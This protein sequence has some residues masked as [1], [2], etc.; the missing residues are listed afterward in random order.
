MTRLRQMGGATKEDRHD[1]DLPGT[2][3]SSRKK[4]LPFAVDGENAAKTGS[5][6]AGGGAIPVSRSWPG[7]RVSGPRRG[8]QS[9]VTGQLPQAACLGDRL[10]GNRQPNP[11]C[12][13][14]P[15]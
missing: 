12:R 5:A 2:G 15:T 14:P 4:S 9:R 3:R 1:L 6:A 11:H 7:S 13:L 8:A 10:P